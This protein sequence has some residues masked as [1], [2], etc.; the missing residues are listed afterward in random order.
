MGAHRLDRPVG[1]GEPVHRQEV[2]ALL[3]PVVVVVGPGGA[4][5]APKRVSEADG[6]V[7]LGGGDVTEV[8]LEQAH[9]RLE[10]TRFEEAQDLD[11]E[12]EGPRIV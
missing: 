7:R 9:A 8:H 6:H 2:D 11:Q 1:E 3:D 10:V 4:G 5:T 12:G